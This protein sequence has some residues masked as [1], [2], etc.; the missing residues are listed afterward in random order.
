MLNLTKSRSLLKVY[1]AKI[2]ILN[3]VPDVKLI[4][5]FFSSAFIETEF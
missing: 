4:S 1:F 5:I 2:L 3:S